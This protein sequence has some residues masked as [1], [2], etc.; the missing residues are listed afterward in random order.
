MGGDYSSLAAAPDGRFHLL[1]ADS[2]SGVFQ[3]HHTAF[4]LGADD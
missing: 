3:I 2:R 4:T 1:W